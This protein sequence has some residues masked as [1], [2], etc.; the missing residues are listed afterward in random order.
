[1]LQLVVIERVLR[2]TPDDAEPGGPRMTVLAS[3]LYLLV[4]VGIAV[5]VVL[6]LGRAV[7]ADQARHHLV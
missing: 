1:M 7:R 6:Q 5:V 4:G 2:V 3:I